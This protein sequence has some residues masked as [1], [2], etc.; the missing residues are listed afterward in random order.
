MFLVCALTAGTPARADDVDRTWLDSY[1]GKT[2][3]L[4]LQG[5]DVVVLF[6][7]D[8]AASRRVEIYARASA[9]ASTQR[10]GRLVPVESR[11]YSQPYRVA[12]AR[13]QRESLP[14]STPSTGSSV[15][16]DELE[17]WM[18]SIAA[19]GEVERV[20]PAVVDDEGFVKHY[21]PGQ[22]IVQFRRSLSDGEC[23][24][25]IAA[26]G[27]V[28]LEDYWTPGFYKLGIPAQTD[29]FTEIRRWFA[30]PGV[31]FAEPVY[32]GY[33]DALLVPNDPL[34]PNQWNMHN[35][36][37]VWTSGAD[38]QAP[39][40]WDFTRGT[41]G[42]VIAIVDTGMDLDH[43]DLAANLLPRNGADWD[44]ADPA[45]NSPDDTNDVF[46]GRHGTAVCGI[47]AAVQGNGLGVSGIA[48]KASLMP[49]RINVTE[50]QNANRADAINYAASRRAEF[51]AMIINCSWRMSAGDMTSVQAAVQVADSLDCV[52][53]AS[54]GNLNSGTI[55][56]PARYPEV[57]AVGATTPCD[58]RMRPVSCVGSLSWGSN[59]GPELDVVAPGVLIATT[60][61]AGSEGYVGGDYNTSFFGTSAAAP[62]ASGIC[63]LIYSVDP[64]LSNDEVRQ[65][66]RDSAEDMVGLVTED[67]PGFDIYMGYGRV[68]AYQ[69]VLTAAGAVDVYVDSFEGEGPPWSESVL[70]QGHTG[71]WHLSTQRNHTMFGTMAWKCGA[72]DTTAYLETLDAALVSP[73]IVLTSDADLQFWH[74]M[75]AH[76]A[77]G[78]VDALDGGR[79]E[80]TDDLGESWTPLTPSGGYSHL[81]G[82][83]DNAFLLGEPVYS[84]SID[85][86]PVTVDLGAYQNKLV[87]IRFH[88]ASRDSIPETVTREGWY[89]D[90]IL[91]QPKAAAGVPELGLPTG[92]PLDLSNGFPN[93]F[94]E[95]TSF[96]LRL[97]DAT[98]VMLEVTDASGRR[99]FR[100][101][102]GRLDAG[103]HRLDLDP[104]AW[105]AL[106]SGHVPRGVY[107]TR[108]TAGA[109]SATRRI[110]YLP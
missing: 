74:Y 79:I 98:D 60:D 95:A 29:E 110:T 34:Y 55:S 78:S 36:G 90:D 51:T 47:A 99:L 14:G 102:L 65:I 38:V 19:M 68:N 21:V 46:L 109:S 24:A 28:V 81:W 70:A 42:T 9:A 26:A 100:R 58:A 49:L 31:L 52:I 103:E 8:V 32:M 59:Y 82:S 43:P 69:A 80:I 12:V 33:D 87:R 30:T 16:P 40:A 91:I 1:T 7:E 22:V 15:A 48:P 10:S 23:R 13:L 107:F 18:R 96:H 108:V 50:G 83:S 44:F 61:M 72:A 37:D 2:W 64:T 39:E 84:G 57:I 66:L 25:L 101:A 5:Q 77:A 56:Y 3:S 27:Q 35:P 86:T 6:R 53:V 54:S 105:T 11:P 62:L 71:A 45:D 92:R 41:P 73:P 20:A 89:I 85:W 93:P 94:P 67:T 88:F 104:R 76:D 106:G 97:S 63:A 75:D 17:R 4:T